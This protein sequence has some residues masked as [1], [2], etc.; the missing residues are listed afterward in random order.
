M[1]AL[2]QKLNHPDVNERLSALAELCKA[3]G[4]TPSEDVNNHIHTFYSFS[5]YSPSAAVYYARKAGLATAGIMDHDSV[6][7]LDEFRKAGEIANLPVTCGLEIRVSFADS[8]FSN[9]RVNNPDQDGV[10]YIALHALPKAGQGTVAEALKKVAHYRGLRNRKMV[11]RLNEI[12]KPLEIELSYDKDVLPLSKAHEGGSV[13]ERHLLY[14]L[15]QKLI[16]KFGKGEPILKALER[17]S[18]PVSEKNR[19]WLSDV[20]S[21]HYAYDLLGALKGELVAS[22]YVD[23]KEELLSA[24]EAIA[25]ANASGAIAAYA[26]L[27]DVTDSV[28]GDKRQQAFEDSDLE[29]LVEYLAETGFQAVTYMPSRN[30]KAQLARLKRLC[31]AKGL[32]QISGEDI[33]SPRQNFICYAA[34]DPEFANL[35]DAAWALIGSE[36]AAEKDVSNAMFGPKDRADR[37]GLSEKLAYYKGLAR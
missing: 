32:L 23:A 10:A 36:K 20:D 17:L 21:P 33:N 13:T 28:T 15:S 12:I 31:E 22:F 37:P 24:K 27:G 7:G 3:E 6:A 4:Y 25:L 35:V 14:A 5:P 9:R 19:R 34:R 29:E 26:Y 8:P 30:T 2:L 16:G 11:E 1:Q 18:I